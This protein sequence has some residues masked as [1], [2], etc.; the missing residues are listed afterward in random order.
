VNVPSQRRQASRTSVRADHSDRCALCGGQGAVLHQGAPDLML[1][2]PGRW[3]VLRCCSA[4]C[5]LL[6]LDPRPAAEELA[7]FYRDGYFTHEPEVP[8]SGALGLKDRVRRAIQQRLLGYPGT[9]DAPV[10]ALAFGVSLLPWFRAAALRD[11]FWLPAPD[12]GL[13]LDIGCGNGAPMRRFIEA[14][15]SAT[16]IDADA[17]AVAAARSAG[18]DARV[19]TLK[20]QRFADAQFDLIVMSH[21]IEHLP[22]PVG[23]L[24]ECRRILKPSGS[25]AIATPNA[26]SLGHRLCGRYWPG[27]DTPR[28]LQIFTPQSLTRMLAMAG[29]APL[30][31]RTHAGI[32]ANWMLA[33]QWWRDAEATGRAGGLPAADTPIPARWVAVARLQ[34][35]GCALGASWGDELVGRY[36]PVCAPVARAVSTGGAAV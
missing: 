16:G 28:H 5:G 34:A 15:W 2:T 19:G 21:V 30:W 20:A 36:A 13:L 7:G 6:W 23:E 9:T 33:G 35:I 10:R 4:D 31:V 24:Q 32:A 14:G 25:I 11:L 22:D 18:L 12:R 29:F 17:Q 27:L 1:G 3:T 26:R 8:L